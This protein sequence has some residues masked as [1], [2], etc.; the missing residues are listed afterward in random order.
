MVEEQVFVALG[1]NLGDRAAALAGAV[2][3][4]NEHSEVEVLEISPVYETEPVG[5]PPQADYLNA[6]VRLSTTLSP[7]D[8]LRVQLEIEMRA[9][10]R[11]DG[12][13]NSAR[14]LDLDLLL[15]GQR[16][17][18]EPGL[19]VPHPRMAERSFVLEPLRDLAP[20]LSPPGLAHNIDEL[21]RR[22]RPEGGLRPVRGLQ[23]YR[24]ASPTG[25]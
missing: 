19:I 20:K 7:Q 21:A 1:S 2:A 18:H 9:G 14:V 16:K 23:L 13:R 4:L 17:L 6:V 8:L 15:Y 10:R 22:V 5:P 11:R 12:V 3:A 25:A 24:S